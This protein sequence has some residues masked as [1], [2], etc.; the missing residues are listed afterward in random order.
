MAA[1]HTF[2]SSVYRAYTKTD[3]ILDKK[4]NLNKLTIMKSHAMFSPGCNQTRNVTKDK[5]KKTSNTSKLYITL[6]SN[7]CIKEELSRKKF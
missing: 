3:H 5:K 7:P 6:L 4:T 2:F 1:K